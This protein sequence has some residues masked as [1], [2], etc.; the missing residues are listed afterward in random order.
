[1]IFP[2]PALLCYKLPKNG[3]IREKQIEHRGRAVRKG[4]LRCYFACIN[5]GLQYFRR[6]YPCFYPLAHGFCTS[7][8]HFTHFDSPLHTFRTLFY[9]FT[10]KIHPF[11]GFYTLVQPVHKMFSCLPSLFSI[12]RA[13]KTVLLSK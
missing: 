6:A 5:L 12:L 2:F 3:K 1:M 4:D 10:H 13:A 7:P 8:L 11:H 9:T